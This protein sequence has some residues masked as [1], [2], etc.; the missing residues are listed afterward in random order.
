MLRMHLTLHVPGLLLPAAIL[1]DSVFDISA[2][3]LSLVL[4]RGRRIAREP[5]WLAGAFGLVAP[6]PAA[7]LRQADPAPGPGLCLD[8]VHFNVTREGILLADPAGL[9]LEDAEAAALLETI[10]P[11]FADLGALTASATGRWELQLSRDLDLATLP[12]AEAIGR[13]VDPGLP[14]GADGRELRRR[15]AEA[16]TVLHAHPVN[17]NREGLGQPTVSSLWPWG[18]GSLPT[19]VRSDFSVAWSADP[20]IAGLCAQA[21]L[22]CL[23]PPG[24]FQ[25]ATGRVLAIDE[26]LAPPAR[27]QDVLRWRTALLELERDWIAPA[28]AALKEGSCSEL[29]VIGTRLHGAP[30]AV[31][32][33]LRRNDRWQFWKR[34]APLTALA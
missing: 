22:P 15:L 6:L 25:P 19:Q 34:P 33:S 20:V 28:V 23:M 13:P 1:P 9:K 8:P 18:Q 10:A 32:F 24:G 27:A 21:G 5:D 29:S 31:E 7:A 4:G 3:G 12:L 14:G 30:A 2:P 11:L 16:Q 17:R 26:R